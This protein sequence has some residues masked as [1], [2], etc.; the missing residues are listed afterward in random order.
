MDN[1]LNIIH[2]MD[3]R[4]KKDDKHQIEIDE[5]VAENIKMIFDMYIQGKTGSQIANFLN[6]KK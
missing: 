3:T 2:L 4:R 6:D 5:D 1:M